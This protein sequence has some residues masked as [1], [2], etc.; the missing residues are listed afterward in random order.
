MPGLRWL[1]RCIPWL[2]VPA[3]ICLAGVSCSST[4]GSAPK[5]FA[6]ITL[7]EPDAESIRQTVDA[8]F[9]EAGYFDTSNRDRWSYDRRSSS[10][11]QFV[12]GGWFDEEQVRVRVKLHLAARADGRH[13]LEAVAV[14]VR[15]A[16]EAFFE[17]ENRMTRLRR[18]PYQKLL[19]EVARRLETGS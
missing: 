18:E 2:L 14:T 8:V 4:S 15:D 19:N 7:A 17:E 1:N 12:H 16:G 13:Q 5:K 9:Q 11:E 3:L 10:M 6:T